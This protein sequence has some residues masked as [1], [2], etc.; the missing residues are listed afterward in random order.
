M[1][2]VRILCLAAVA[3]AAMAFGPTAG[4][5]LAW[6]A[7]T[8]ATST[9]FGGYAGP[10]TKPVTATTNF[11]LEA[12]T[13]ASTNEGMAPGVVLM[14]TSTSVISSGSIF[15]SCLTGTPSYSAVAVV[16]NVQ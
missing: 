4:A 5:T 7:T 11:K 8:N 9:T 15:E 6:A 16:N 10:V 3:A 1:R 13:C 12:I 14:D 2:T